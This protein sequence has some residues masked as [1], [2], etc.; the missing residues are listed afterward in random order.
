MSKIIEPLYGQWSRSEMLPFVTNQP[1]TSMEVACREGLFSRALKERFDDLTTWGVD[2]DP[3]I[4]KEIAETH[5]DK[6]I[7]GYFP[8]CLD[9]IPDVLF[10]LIIFNDV[11]EHIYDPWEA[12]ENARRRLTNEGILVVSLPNIRHR[13]VI[14]DLLLKNEFRYETS[15]ILDISHIRFFTTK[16]MLR[17]F[18]ECGFDVVKMEPLVDKVSFIKKWRRKIINTITG[19]KF[20]SLYYTQYGFTLK[21]K[22]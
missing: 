5:L 7:S 11:L 22:V 12:L 2:P 15:G 8:Q 1:K 16:S 6:F 4:R 19:G 9:K 10:D 14:K 20:E 3:T 17:L 21:K 18:D 13:K